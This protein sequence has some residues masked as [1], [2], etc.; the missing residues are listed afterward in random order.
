M[1][2]DGSGVVREILGP[3]GE[4]EDGPLDEDLMPS[5]KDGAADPI[6]K[7]VLAEAEAIGKGQKWWSEEDDLG[8]LVG[9]EAVAGS[10]DR[11]LVVGA[12]AH[13]DEGATSS[14]A[15]GIGAAGLEEEDLDPA[16]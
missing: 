14:V 9:R 5:W 10:I 2:L 3:E 6:L 13:I 8:V 11:D 12:I 16:W 4:E 1:I 7:V 15:N